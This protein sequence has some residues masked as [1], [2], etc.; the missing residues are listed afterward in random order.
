MCGRFSLEATWDE[1]RQWYNIIG[2][3]AN[4]QPRYNIAPTQSI[5]ILLL[6]DEKIIHRSMRWGLIPSWTKTSDRLPVLINARA[7]TA[8]EKPS[9]RAALRS[10]RGLIPA[11]GYYEWKV[12]G[13]NKTPHYITPKDGGLMMFAGLWE[14]WTPGPSTPEDNIESCTILTTS[15]GESIANV[16][17]RMPVI[18]T[19]DQGEEWLSA[20]GETLLERSPQPK[21]ANWPVSRKVNKVRNEGEYLIKPQNCS[22]DTFISEKKNQ[23]DL[24]G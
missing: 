16:H 23:L 10:R 4:L 17:H 6:K 15:A 14:I 11:S 21:L 5:S 9:F 7:E 2:P 18:L 3:A 24:F 12:E 8:A 22:P 13:E 1:L 19:R 20:G